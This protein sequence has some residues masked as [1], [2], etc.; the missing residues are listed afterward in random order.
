MRTLAIGLHMHDDIARLPKHHQDSFWNVPSPQ[1]SS[2]TGANSHILYKG[3]AT[4]TRPFSWVNFVRM[5]T[6]PC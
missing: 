6:D 1:Q 3:T 5:R 2:H 4:E